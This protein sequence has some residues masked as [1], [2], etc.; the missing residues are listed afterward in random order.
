L[1]PE[2][3]K[4]KLLRVVLIASEHTIREYP[5]F[6]QHLL[7]GLADESIP[8]AFICPPVF[9]PASIFTGAAEV[10]SHPAFGLPLMDHINTRLLVERLE[11]FEPTIIHCL[12]E[13]KASLA[14]KLAHRLDL[15]YVLAVNSLQK[16]WRRLSISSKYCEKIVVP[17][18]SLA[19][20]MASYHPRFAERVAQINMGTFVAEDLGCFSDTSGIAT[21]VI[22][23][24]LK[25]AND[26]EN[27]LS[28]IRHLLID[29]YEFMAVIV[30][31][32]RAE[33]QLWKLLDALGLLKIVTIV[34]GQLPWRSV[35][36][37]ADIFIQ[38]QPNYAFN[39]VLL[40]AMSV[41]AAVA[42]CTGGV[43]DLIIE[44]QTAVVFDPNDE[45]SIMRALQPLLDRREMARQIA[46]NAQQYLKENHS[47]SKI[48]SATLKVYYEAQG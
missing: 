39:A 28:V 20:N 46:R 17:A 25:R 12:C 32:G 14:R 27:L 21:I 6:L 44:G 11:K 42:G 19:D 43:D 18:K 13:S 15:P 34:P 16:R 2:N 33:R 24:S 4:K 47:V 22:D 30:G 37:A 35:L 41:G 7:V 40:Q 45:M 9:N 23:D 36:A 31:G 5:M 38:P 29:G 8:A 3:V 48:I 26:I 1:T 10:I